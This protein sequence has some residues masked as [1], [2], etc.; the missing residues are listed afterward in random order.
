MIGQ[1]SYE[2]MRTLVAKSKAAAFLKE[3]KLAAAILVRKNLDKA[4]TLGSFV[5]VS[6]MAMKML[7]VNTGSYIALGAL[8]TDAGITFAR[9]KIPAFDRAMS[10]VDNK[11]KPVLSK[12]EEALGNVLTGIEKVI[13]DFKCKYL[14]KKKPR[15]IR[16][17][18]IDDLGQTI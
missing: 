11:L 16:K 15:D 14:T 3:G 10:K 13:R 6:G 9:Y 4:F 7:G 18:D 1:G 8:V 12:A 17:S 2:N 5:A